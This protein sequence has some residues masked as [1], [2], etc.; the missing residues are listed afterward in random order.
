MRP[1][2][3]LALLSTLPGL[4][5][6][7]VPAVVLEEVTV[8]SATRT[9]RA[10]D[11]SPVAVEV[12]TEQEIRK[13]GAV[14]L[15]DVLL[16]TPGVFINPGR[17]DIS[18]RGAGAKGTLLLVDGRRLAGEAGMGFELDRIPAGSIERIEVV[19]G[20]MGVLYGSDALGGIIN[21][22]TK[23]PQDGLEGMVSTSVG[24]TASGDAERYEVQGD[25]RGRRGDTGFSAWFNASRQGEYSET[26]TARVMV[27]RGGGQQGAA[28]PSQSN[29]NDF[30]NNLAD[31]YRVEVSYREPTDLLSV[32]GRL[33]QRLHERLE[34]GMD[35]SYL[36][37]TRDARFVG[38]MHPSNYPLPNGQT[39]P[40]RNAPVEN[41][42][43]NDR[44]DVALRGRLEPTD[45][46][47]L[48]WRSH[49]SR[50]EK[51]ETITSPIWND[52]GYTSQGASASVS[53][54]G[55]V[56]VHGHEL[57]G[58]W[59][60]AEAHTV[61]AGAEYRDE[62]RSAPFFNPDNIQE[63][64][65]YWFRSLFAQHEWRLSPHAEIIYGL[66]HDDPSQS[67]S[68]NSGSVGLQYIIHPQA[69][70]RI[71]Y[72]EGFRIADLPETFLNRET[73][74]GRL[75]GAS[76]TDP[77][78]G[79]EAFE[80]D[81]ERSENIEVGISGQGQGWR[82]DIA[83]F[84]STID[85]RIERTVEAP[86]GI[87]YTTF[88]NISEARI[89]GLELG[90]SYRFSPAWTVSASA[91]LLETENRETGEKLEFEPDLQARIEV[92][93]RPAAAWEL[94]LAV[95]H[96]GTQRYTDTPGEPLARVDPYTL[97]D[98]RVSY[99]PPALGRV[100]IFGGVENLFDTRV[101][102]AVGSDPGPFGY[103][104]VRYFY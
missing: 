76:V 100:D 99:M 87:T 49:R 48:D 97:T 72:A 11:A 73:P 81:P 79:K 101:D 42:W 77:A 69:R 58:T 84:Q 33:T 94:N 60:P 54:T 15:R 4:A 62:K 75:A 55:E 12:V 30:R 18:I 41:D 9:D 40:V 93:W 46:L 57:T 74:R 24:A 6:A 98:L 13:R 104:G 39:A 61:L 102:T 14:T 37:E 85:D 1:V 8:T 88:R 36:R 38:N 10:R 5:L 28:P 32:G 45:T 47:Q 92:D 68:A 64:R 90:T 35:V 91:G 17:G 95:R 23:Q 70:L 80:L 26:G 31:T 19:K 52:L 44:L 83:V 20:P 63:S 2:P 53:G 56:T 65:D 66:R 16:N 34:L 78:L 22:I 89:R 103:V 3:M 27:P 50:Y 96:T 71:N 82:Y 59:R 51:D 67:K 29:I 43:E 25:I 21:I 7:D 86:R